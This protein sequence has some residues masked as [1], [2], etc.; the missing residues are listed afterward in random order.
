MQ[1]KTLVIIAVPQF[2]N[3]QLDM[4]E[5]WGCGGRNQN[6]QERVQCFRVCLI[7][8]HNLPHHKCGSHTKSWIM[9]D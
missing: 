6:L 7:P 9:L 1:Q 8:C 3:M 5:R 2:S 4:R